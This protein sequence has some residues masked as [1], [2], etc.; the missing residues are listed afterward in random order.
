MPLVVSRWRLV[1]SKYSCRRGSR[2]S[3]PCAGPRRLRCDVYVTAASSP[4]SS[5]RARR[6]VDRPSAP[7]FQLARRR[8]PPR[9][10]CARVRRLARR[11]AAGG[12]SRARVGLAATSSPED[13]RTRTTALRGRRARRDR[14][15]RRG[16][17]AGLAPR[18]HVRRCCCRTNFSRASCRRRCSWVTT[19]FL[20]V[21]LVCRLGRLRRVGRPPACAPYRI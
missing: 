13:A 1:P 19:G 10:S 8:C 3:S 20:L 14:R 9:P 18:A 5:C 21:R 12:A 6:L 17:H 7:F 15:D 11:R 4:A 2:T 16:A